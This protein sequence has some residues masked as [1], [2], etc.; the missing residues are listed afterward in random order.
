M[1]NS[2]WK[3]GESILRVLDVLESEVLIIDCIKLTMPRWI[4]ADALKG[5]ILCEE[6]VLS[7]VFKK[8]GTD[9][10]LADD[11]IMHQRFTIIA[12]ILPFISDEKERG[13]MI[14][15]MGKQYGV[16]QPTVRRYLCRY[17]AYQDIAALAPI[18]ER[19]ARRLTSDEANIQ[20]ALNKFW[21]TTSRLSR[22]PRREP[23]TRS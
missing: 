20:W 9:L 11:R 21:Q 14:A 10:D 13:R 6:T 8:Q 23:E 4:E 22:E 18:R 5:Y 16:T 12:G 3:K 17:L 1:K 2:L 19:D 7:N 15:V